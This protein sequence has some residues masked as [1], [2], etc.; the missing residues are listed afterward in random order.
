MTGKQINTKFSG[1][2]HICEMEQWD[3]DYFNMEVQAYIEIDKDN[4][5]HFQFGLVS[6][7]IDGEIC[8]YGTTD[9]FEFTFEGNDEC[10]SA[11]GSGWFELK[12]KNTI[13]GRIKFHMGEVSTFVAKQSK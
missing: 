10:D 9:R 4:T 11:S 3:A 13:E 12:D 2:W 8:K 5:G 7:E 1:T 6:G